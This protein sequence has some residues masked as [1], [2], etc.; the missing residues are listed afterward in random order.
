VSRHAVPVSDEE[1]AR[2]GNLTAAVVAAAV[3]V[4]LA[5]P[6][7]AGRQG[8]LAATAVLQ[9]LLVYSWV[10]GTA[11]PGRVGALLLGLGTAAGCDVLVYRMP[12]EGLAP[13]LDV[14]PAVFVLAIVHQLC[15]GVVRV[16]VTESLA[17]VFTLCAAVAALVGYLALR[18]TVDGPTLVSV[19]VTATGLAM[20]AGHLVDAVLPVPRFD[21]GVQHGLL[22]VV[23]AAAAG[24]GVGWLRVSQS[25]LSV[26]PR[27]GAMLGGALGLLAALVGVGIAYVCEAVRPLRVPFAGFTLPYVRAV[28]PFAVTAPVALVLG[29][30][31]AG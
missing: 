29:M 13:I 31:V 16:R 19:A 25:A 8:L 21:R 23:V 2:Q 17:H 7:L 9:A 15:R 5:V 3:T 18:S 22:G 11:M 24:A 1:Q 6:S 14:F 30:A 26:E 27:Y 12:H 20:V 10:L 28:L 4:A